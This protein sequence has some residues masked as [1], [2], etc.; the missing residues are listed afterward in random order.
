MRVTQ[1]MIVGNFLSNLN[2]SF[3]DMD[4]IQRQLSTGRKITKPS[5]DPVAIASS[6]RLRSGLAETDKYTANVAQATSW[7]NS[8]DTAL[9]QVGDLLQQTRDLVVRGASGTMPQTSME[10]I[11]NEIYQIREQLLQVGNTTHDGR[12]IF[13]GFQTTAA[14]FDVTT[15]AYSG[16]VTADIE[17][18]IGVNIKLN[19]NVTGQDAFLGAG[20][21][22][23]LLSDI[24]TDLRNGDASSLSNSRIGAVDTA[25][26]NLLSIRAD[27]G[28]RTNRLELTK[29]RL[30]EGNINLSSLL[31][32]VEDVNVAEAITQL[33]MQENSYRT[34]LSAGARIIQPT[35]MDFLR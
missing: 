35:L 28:A 7:L 14:P 27:V 8:T 1:G 33:K 21:V 29:T 15:G 19:I 2:N 31:S 4:K 24:E 11:A 10:A 22:F 26:D 17:Y 6:L 12:Y 34:A 13:G 30:E 18:E 3:R 23:T 9:G 5:D 16:D 32:S 20:D 25:I